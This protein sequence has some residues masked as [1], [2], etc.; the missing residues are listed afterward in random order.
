MISSGFFEG[1]EGINLLQG[2]LP[3]EDA[4]PKVA[5]IVK[6]QA[7]L[8]LARMVIEETADLDVSEDDLLAMRKGKLREMLDI[9]GIGPDNDITTVVEEDGCNA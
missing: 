9:I 7:Q 8:T 5:P 2:V 1:L 6:K 3:G 4:K